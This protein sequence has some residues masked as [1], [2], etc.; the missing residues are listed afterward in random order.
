MPPTPTASS[1]RRELTAPGAEA[2]AVDGPAPGRVEVRDLGHAYGSVE[3]LAGVDLDVAPG[4]FV[5]VLGPSGCGKSTLLKVLAGLV[6]PTSGRAAIDGADV[7]AHPGRA[8]YQPQRDA[9]LPW[10]RVV[11]NAALGAELAGRP[12]EEARAE[13]TALL[14]RFGL[15]GFE[16]AWPA[17]LSGG[18]RQRVAVARTFLTG[19][20]PLLLD[21]PFGALDALTRRDLYS[22][23][24]EVWGGEA[25]R[26]AT[27]L[28]T[29]DVDEALTLA[30]RVVV[31]SAR[32][33]R[34]VAEE[35][36]P[37]ARPRRPARLAEAEWSA[38]RARLLT[39][40]SA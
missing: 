14:A 12:R 16:R 13:A 39:A 21:E 4:E 20:A 40:L 26:P 3:V 35:P 15:A 6:A 25:G 36:V 37:F 28:V 11:A 38:A 7:A 8:A 34:V 5:A 23:L 18:M 31:L 33:G 1:R 24:E 9:L 2:G 27:L 10:R 17:Q 29:H 19:R 32:P 22:W 30:D